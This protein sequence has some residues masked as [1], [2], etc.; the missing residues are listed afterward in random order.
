M[1]GFLNINKPSGKTSSNV[2]VAVRKIFGQQ[3]VGHMGT[4]DPMAS[5][6]LPI[7][8][9]KATRL[10]DY[11]QDKKKEYIAVFEFG[12]ETDTLDIEGKIQRKTD[13]I[14]SEEQIEKS[15]SLFHGKISQMPP[16]YSAKS[17]DGVRAYKLARQGV[18]V[19][20]QPKE[21]EIYCFDLLEKINE[22]SFRFKIICSSGT[23]IR[24]LCRDLAYKLSSLATMAFL[25]RTST[26][27]FKIEQAIQIE[28][29][30]VSNASTSLI[31]VTEVFKNFPQIHINEQQLYDLSSGKSIE[32]E[33]KDSENIFAI[34]NSNPVGLGK[35]ENNLLR[36]KT[37]LYN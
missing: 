32:V 30:S 6:V 25:E 33:Q 26:G 17:I 16:Q 1:I 12:Y 14:P 7:A 37:Y 35:V 29:L 5:G 11:F 21:V 24:S 9:G 31:P 28:D 34:F 13:N 8:V 22:K 23:Y 36:L 4:L 18:E 3:K 19:Q 2:V 10:F 27:I 20:L 15:L